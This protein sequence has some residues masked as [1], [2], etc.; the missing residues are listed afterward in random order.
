MADIK[1]Q[2]RIGAPPAKVY[3]YLTDSKK[4]R[5]WQGV[6]AEIEPVPGGVFSMV[7]GSGMNARGRFIE[8]VADQRVVFTWGW[9]GHD[10]IPPGSTTVEIELFPDG[11]GTLLTLTHRSIPEGEAPMQKMG[12]E[13][14]LPRLSVVA[15]GKDPGED[16]GPG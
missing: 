2:Q 8:L 15:S 7:M 13:H 4:W 12:W 6:D 10:G 9:V 11:S 14:Y 5:M 16:P 3:R 1:L